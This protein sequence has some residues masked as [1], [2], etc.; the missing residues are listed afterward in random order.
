MPIQSD[1]K[2]LPHELIPKVAENL[3]RICELLNTRY[4]DKG[5]AASQRLRHWL[6]GKIQGAEP[7]WLARHLAEEQVDLLFDAFFQD[8]PFG[9]GGRRGPVG[10]G[11]NRLNPTTV[12]MTVQGHADYLKA[13]YPDQEIRVVVAN[14]V[15]EFHDLGGVYGFLT[16]DHPLRGLSS[17]TLARFACEIYA[18]N[19]IIAYCAEPE[20]DKAVLTTPELSFCIRKLDAQGGVN[21]SASHNPPDDNGIKVYDAFG[22]QPVAPEDQRLVEVMAATESFQSMPFDE[23]LATGRVKAIP[24]DLHEE[25][26]EGYVELYGDLHEPLA[27]IPIAYT[28]LCGS[29]LT[30]AAELMQRIGF[31]VR[32]PPDE[33]PNGRFTPI[34]FRAPNP[35]VPQATAP[36]RQFA[37]QEGATLVLS[38]DPDADRVGAE[39]RLAD[40][41][42]YHLDGNQIATIL[43]YYLMLDPGGPQKRG[44]VIETLVTNK[45]LGRIVEKAGQSWIVDD[46]LVG[47]KYVA[48]VLKALGAEGRYG[49]IVCSPADLVLAAEESH[50][51]VMTPEILDKDGA[52]ACLF[53]AAV[54]QR[55]VSE[56]RDLLAYYV[57]ILEHVGAFDCVNR[58]IM[59]R[60]AE[61]MLKKD[62]IMESLRQSPPSRLCGVQ[63]GSFSDYWDEDR[64]GPFLSDTDK[65]SRNV[66]Q[67]QCSGLVL[68]IRPSGTEPK[69]KLYVQVTPEALAEPKRG[70]ELLAQIRQR[71]EEIGARG[72]NELLAL[73]DCKLGP[74]SLALP[75]LVDLDRKLR[76]EREIV[77]TMAER[78]RGDAV[79]E[80]AYLTWLKEACDWLMPGADP[81]PALKAPLRVVLEEQAGV[82]KRARLD[83]LED[84]ARG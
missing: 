66:V 47:F 79:D 84:W 12:G 32:V 52:P 23:A 38:T 15:R 39:I 8:L 10:Y 81:M 70:H 72:Y 21:L 74:A 34:P 48:K 30:T 80:E 63:V 14:D 67:F 45:I 1:E 36:A 82:S 64:F 19:G 25:Y 54:H 53:L 35:E 60:G 3:D 49:D 13:A 29:G 26:L 7:Q 77:P 4:G 59:M 22:S 41:S 20:V 42:W 40:G 68:T 50:G 43:G 71:G 73:I 2:T 78:L 17:R 31:D 37:E 75:D 24:A 69:L 55:A 65:A 33:G 76:F 6:S 83:R 5:Q 56:G 62:R 51:I 27:D 11:A 9:T 61:G 58:S 18:G 57:D 28:P 16:E 44:L 46:L